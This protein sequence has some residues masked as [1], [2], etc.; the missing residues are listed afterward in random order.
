[1]CY[2]KCRKSYLNNAKAKNVSLSISQVNTAPFWSNTILHFQDFNIKFLKHISKI[3]V[4]LLNNS[5]TPKKVENPS[6]RISLFFKSHHWF[7]EAETVFVIN[8][9]DIDKS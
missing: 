5:L 3:S 1:M 4:P 7:I 2:F 6:F 8:D 9:V